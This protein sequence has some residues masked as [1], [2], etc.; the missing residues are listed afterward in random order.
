MGEA[1]GWFVMMERVAEAALKAPDAVPLSAEGA[2]AAHRALTD[3]HAGW[4]LFAW[5]V[6]SHLG[7]DDHAAAGAG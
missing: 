7:P 6:A 4:R 3:P 1:V 2:V 5:L